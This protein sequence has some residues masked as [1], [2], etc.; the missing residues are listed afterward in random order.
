[1][2][3]VKDLWTKRVRLSEGGTQK[4]KSDRH[5][6]G[7]RWLAVWEDPDGRERSAAFERKLDAENK[8]SAMEVDIQR[9]D[10]IDP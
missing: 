8:V 2:G 9:G 1:M 3:Y 10:Y 4:V 5:G 6:K 7:K